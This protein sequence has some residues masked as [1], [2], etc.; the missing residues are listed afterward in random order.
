MT[1]LQLPAL[2]QGS[3][4]S[5]DGTPIGYWKTGRGPA[6]VVLHGSMESART[7]TLLAQALADDFT[8]YLPDRRGRGLSG[9][10]RPDHS[11]R[12]EV[13]DLEAV[14][15]EA[16][17]SLA[18]GV[19]ASGAI[20]LEAARTLPSLRK[21]AVYEPALVADA[22]RHIAWLA[23]FDQEIAQGNVAAAMIT[24][25]YGLE[26]APAAFKV[27][28]RRL[29]ASITEK[30]LKKEDRQAGPHDLTLRKLAPTV[31]YEGAL[32]VELAGRI[33]EFRSVAAEVL[34]LGG[35]KGLPFLK[36]SRDALEKVLPHCRRVEFDGFDH[37][38]SSD[39]SA[40]NSTGSA[41]AIERIA[42]EIRSFF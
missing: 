29:L 34:L 20:V 35:S 41:K 23:R 27:M 14:L 9:P 21:V 8:V 3:V 1:N 25:M 7:H 18:F 16:D 32:I 40:I 42:S 11:V 37:G 2:I 38:S 4:A 15:R 10:H 6:L 13:G 36:P 30:M 12:T 5:Q 19:S 28:P 17:A 31:H 24:S 26:L 39:P 33:D 22:A